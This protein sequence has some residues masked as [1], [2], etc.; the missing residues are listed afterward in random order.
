MVFTYLQF[1]LLFSGF[2]NSCPAASHQEPNPDK[3]EIPN[4]KYQIPNKLQHAAQASALLVTEIQNLKHT[5]DIEKQTYQ[6]CFDHWILE[7]VICL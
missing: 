7:F 4:H 6:N 3:P 5:Q 1:G 2:R